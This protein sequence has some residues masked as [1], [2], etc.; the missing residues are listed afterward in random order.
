MK[1][2]RARE[3][4]AVKQRFSDQKR[5]YESERDKLVLQ[6]QAE[7]RQL[8]QQISDK[9]GELEGKNKTMQSQKDNYDAQ[10]KLKN[11]QLKKQQ[12]TILKQNELIK[13]IKVYS[14]VELLE[15]QQNAKKLLDQTV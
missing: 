1:D 11:N 9:K 12:D 14:Q 3:M 15:S 5:I 2:Q 8:K 7:V 10:L 6:H 4:D 13:Q